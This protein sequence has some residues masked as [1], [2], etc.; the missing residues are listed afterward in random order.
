MAYSTM[1]HDAGG[2]R[3]KGSVSSASV[4]N[5]NDYITVCSTARHRRKTVG[6]LGAL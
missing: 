3:V 5:Y 4:I 6:V 1:A 2:T